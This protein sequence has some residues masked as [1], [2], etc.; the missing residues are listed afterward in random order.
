MPGE[1]SLL[2]VGGGGWLEDLAS[3]Q[4]LS[5]RFFQPKPRSASPAKAARPTTA[6]QENATT[7]ISPKERFR[8]AKQL[9]L[10]LERKKEKGAVDP[11]PP[12][13]RNASQPHQPATPGR[14]GNS[15]G[16]GGRNASSSLEAR[17]TEG[18]AR[19]SRYEREQQQQ[20]VVVDD[21]HQI[22]QHIDSRWPK[23]DRDTGYA[24]RYSRDKS[25]S[26]DDFDESPPASA[27]SGGR[28]NVAAATSM[29]TKSGKKTSPESRDKYTSKRLSRFL[30]RE[31]LESDGYDRIEEFDEPDPQQ[32]QRNKVKRQ[33]SRASLKVDLVQHRC[34]EEP[35]AH[36]H[37]G[38]ASPPELLPPTV[39]GL[40]RGGG[41][42]LLRRE[43]TELDFRG[44]R[45][46]QQASGGI[47]KLF[48]VPGELR[49]PW[50]TAA[51]R[52]KSPMGLPL[53][54]RERALSPLARALSPARGHAVGRFPGE[55]LAGR[56][57][58]GTRV[59]TSEYEQQQHR[60]SRSGSRGAVGALHRERSSL[61]KGY[62][63]GPP[64]PPDRYPSLDLRN[65][66]RKSLYETDLLVRQQLVAGGGGGGAADYRRRSYHE[67]SDVDRIDQQH[68][69]NSNNSRN[70]QHSGRKATTALV[71]AE[72]MVV[73]SGRTAYKHIPEPHRYPGL[74]RDNAPRMN[75]LAPLPFKPSG[76]VPFHH[77]PNHRSGPLSFDRPAM[78]RHSYAD[79]SPPGANFPRVAAGPPAGGGRFGLA[80]LKPY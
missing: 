9:F 33:P 55:E 61:E 75:P 24:S 53:W 12:P 7:E 70:F 79:P 56:F 68:N 60:K 1:D 39:G 22:H 54:G 21:S 30:S 57:P 13:S 5:A 16:A 36:H 49:A 6:A 41:G 52:A 80:S 8:G 63:A 76:P 50:E 69:N 48:G 18:Q 77:H 31:T 40:R 74:D 34:E 10:S 51:A 20:H 2:L 29:F 59:L 58:G 3:P 66:K 46:H 67:L 38:A 62:A 45:G 19:W 73:S 43:M 72:Q 11:P 65:E 64:P 37:R 17:Q 4:S 35:P 47:Q 27:G 28:T 14:V 78:Y 71:A 42:G 32:Q 44:Y 23:S 25:R 26:R 15:N